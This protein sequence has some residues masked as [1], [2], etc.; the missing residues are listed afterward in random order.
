MRKPS[1]KPLPFDA[2]LREL[3]GKA[4]RCFRGSPEIR[5]AG[6]EWALNEIA[7]FCDADPES[8]RRVA[9]D[10]VAKIARNFVA[11]LEEEK[12][13]LPPSQLRPKLRQICEML[14]ASRRLLNS[15]FQMM[16]G[17]ERNFAGSTG[18]LAESL[19]GLSLLVEATQLAAASRCKFRRHFNGYEPTSMAKFALL[20]ECK[21]LLETVGKRAPGVTKKGPV[22]RLARAIAEYA[23][24][25]ESANG[26]FDRQ[27]REL[28]MIKNKMRTSPTAHQG[29]DSRGHIL[30]IEPY[31]RG[32]E[33]R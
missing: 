2:W 14:K 3:S 20:V 1:S 17:V 23:T 10:A 25:E 32:E 33:Y 11:D 21:G 27:V 7:A 6:L 31:P 12:S 19:H 24:G 30:E 13:L 18:A 29:H 22:V 9:A 15:Q 4:R 28:N 26:A 5:Q 8:G 16:I